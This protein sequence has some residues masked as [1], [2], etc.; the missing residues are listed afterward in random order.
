M[1]GVRWYRP[2]VH[3][4]WAGMRWNPRK[5]LTKF[6]DSSWNAIQTLPK[7]VLAFVHVWHRSQYMRRLRA[8]SHQSITHNEQYY[9][10]FK[11]EFK[12]LLWQNQVHIY[13]WSHNCP[14]SWWVNHT[15]LICNHRGV[16]K[17]QQYSHY[18]IQLHLQYVLRAYILSLDVW[19]Q[20]HHD[21]DPFL[22]PWVFSIKNTFLL[23]VLLGFPFEFLP[24]PKCEAPS[25]K[26]S[27]H[28]P[29]CTS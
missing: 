7:Y 25:N 19:K 13:F 11:L 20:I 8:H 14:S 15:M 21:V 10:K 26:G 12:L 9:S 23:N 18:V 6:T 24:E 3:L 28:C 4:C 1:L 2:R 27:A 22:H 17:T 5:M 16:I 29:Q